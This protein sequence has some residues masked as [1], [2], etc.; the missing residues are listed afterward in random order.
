[1]IQRDAAAALAQLDEAVGEGTEVGQL[2]DQL[3]GYFRDAITQA[4]GCDESRL[5]YALPGQVEEVREVAAALGVETLLAIAQILDQT[6]ARLR[7]STQVRTLAEMALVRIAK[8][9]DLDSLAEL[10][11][12]LSTGEAAPS[13]ASSAA[14]SVETAAPRVALKKNVRRDPPQVVNAGSA[15]SDAQNRST[16]DADSRTSDADRGSSDADRGST[17]DTPIRA[18]VPGGGGPSTS[19]VGPSTSAGDAVA[20]GSRVATASPGVQ[21]R[22][23]VTRATWTEAVGRLSGMVADHAAAA[24]QVEVDAR[25]TLVVSFPESLKFS[26]DACGRPANLARIS[27]CL[28]EVHGGPVTLELRTHSDPEGAGGV[29][30]PAKTRRERQQEIAARPFVRNALELF[31]ADATR[32][33]YVPPGSSKGGS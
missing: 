5:L 3:L 20:T 30:N 7:V 11:A 9:G 6:A 12:Q 14:S 17:Q 25:G 16:S 22:G 28:Q 24:T 13:A 19:A 31:D 21:V 1:L 23:E 33:R 4:V 32:M 15:A 26:R 29:S 8:L 10:V 18:R 27:Q 2:I